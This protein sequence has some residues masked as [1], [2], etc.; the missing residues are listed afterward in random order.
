MIERSRFSAGSLRLCG[1]R[2]AVLKHYIKVRHG[3][4]SRSPDPHIE[5]ALAAMTDMCFLKADHQRAEFRQAQPLRHLAAQHPTLGFGPD[6][7]ALAGD[8]E[9]KRQAI[10]VGPLQ[11]A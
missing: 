3:S 10:A 8:D 4:R 7:A 9:H 11:E 2:E 5:R 1:E 6:G